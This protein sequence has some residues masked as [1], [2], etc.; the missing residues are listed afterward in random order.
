M[1]RVGGE[2]GGVALR[3]SSEPSSFA[4]SSAAQTASIEEGPSFD[5]LH[6]C[7]CRRRQG[8]AALGVEARFHDRSPSMRT[9][10]RTRSPQ[11]AP[12]AAPVW[13]QSFS[14]PSPVG[15]FRCSA[16]DRIEGEN[17]RAP[18]PIR[19]TLS[20]VCIT[21][22]G[23]SARVE[24]GPSLPLSDPVVGPAVV[25]SPGVLRGGPRPYLESD[26]LTG[27][28]R[29]NMCG[30]LAYR[31]GPRSS[32]P[33]VGRRDHLHAEL[34]ELALVHGRGRARERVHA[35]GRLR[36]GD[37]VADRARRRRAAPRCGRCRTPRHR[38]AARRR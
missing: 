38:A 24:S 34:V 28:I 15:A 33:R 32:L 23:Q 11:A 8:A 12:P 4:T 14:A 17:Y 31:L 35:A 29:L 3:R 25:A 19:P 9:A 7:A 37:H 2:L 26:S 13:G 30:R 1:E 21:M 36:E 16:N 18:S 22:S 27:V 5:E 6:C 10:M 20:A